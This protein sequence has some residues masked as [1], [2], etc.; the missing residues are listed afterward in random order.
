ME[1]YCDV[2]GKRISYKDLTENKSKELCLAIEGNPFVEL[3]EI[4]KQEDGSEVLIVNVE[5]ELSQRTINDIRNVERMAILVHVG[6]IWLPT[7]LALRKDFPKVPHLNITQNEIPRCLCLYAE[8]YEELKL[9]W[10]NYS[11]IERIREW[12]SLTAKGKLHQED[13]I[14]EPFLLPSF[15]HIVLPDG[16]FSNNDAVLLEVEKVESVGRYIYIT[17]TQGTNDKGSK[18]N[19]IVLPII[20]KA[21]THGII[22]ST[23]QNLSQ[24]EQFLRKA[25]IDLLSFLRERL[26]NWFHIVKEKQIFENPMVFV[27]ALPQKREDEVIPE[28]CQVIGFVTQASLKDIGIALGVWS[29]I[30]RQYGLVVPTDTSSGGETI[31]VE[32]LNVIRDFTR[33]SAQLYNGNAQ[34]DT[35]ISLVGTGALGS[36]IFNNLIRQG[37][38]T[39]TLIDIDTIMPHNLARHI[40]GR[41]DIG[42]S[43][44]NALMKYANALL[45]NNIVESSHQT[46]VSFINEKDNKEVAGKLIESQIILDV[47]ASIPVSRTLTHDSLSDAKRISCF[48]TPSGNDSIIIAEGTNREVK[49]DM[50]EMQYYREIVNNEDFSNHIEKKEGQYRY[51]GACRDLSTIL[52]FEKVVLHGSLMTKEIKKVINSSLPK[53]VVYKTN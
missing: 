32:M 48:Y 15:S 8:Q 42:V 30:E 39:W 40:L 51:G 28:S 25:A 16:I 14:L 18:Q 52:P 47:A 33:D 2:V 1:E 21:H 26:K 11:F 41:F 27:I 4:V 44:A 45:G 38:G 34:E 5:V 3:V 13:Q 50:L 6:D 23:P 46:N 37:I 10:S 12:L 49:L 36:Q 53:I 35:K 29:M 19:C 31:K 17:K 24:L 9:K 20:G 22:E 43:K 7:V